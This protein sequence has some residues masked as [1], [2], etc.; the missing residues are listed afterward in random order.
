ML[1]LIACL[2]LFSAL[3]CNT[4]DGE[5]SKLKDR[6]NEKIN[7]YTTWNSTLDSL[8]NDNSIPN[9]NIFL[10]ACKNLF[11]QDSA[12]YKPE[13]LT[14]KY[15]KSNIIVDE[16]GDNY[17]IQIYSDDYSNK[18]HQIKLYVC[19]DNL[20]IITTDS[21]PGNK[22]HNGTIQVLDWNKDGLEDLK[23][24]ILNP[25]SSITH[26]QNDEKI[27]TLNSDNNFTEIF[28]LTLDERSCTALSDFKGELIQKKY[29]FV[30]NQTIEVIKQEYTFPCENFKF[31]G[32][33]A[34][35]RLRS[36]TKY[37]LK[38]NATKNF[39]EVPVR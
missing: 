20:N 36:T 11:A 6:H 26:C 35:G 28:N 13:D 3:A 14:T 38:W 23:F 21:I 2:I 16:F 31:D 39:F 7:V 15:A 17:L 29:S 12:I 9:K 34:D 5:T 8:S 10:F 4:N 37:L 32:P 24:N 25:T 33:I 19:D 18:S 27:F 30:D 22:Y 1:K